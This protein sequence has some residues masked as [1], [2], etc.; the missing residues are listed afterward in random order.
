LGEE[1]AVEFY[2][3]AAHLH[4]ERVLSPV[5]SI[6]QLQDQRSENGLMESGVDEASK[7]S[8]VGFGLYESIVLLAVVSFS[9]FPGVATCWSLIQFGPSLYW[10]YPDP[11]ITLRAFLEARILPLE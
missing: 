8:Y 11:N 5:H 7:R 1:E 9:L 2:L 4:E 3:L 10:P 6:V